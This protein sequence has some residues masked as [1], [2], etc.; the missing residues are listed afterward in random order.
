MTKDTESL[1][2]YSVPSL[3]CSLL[4]RFALRPTR[5]PEPHVSVCGTEALPAVDDD[6]VR[7]QIDEQTG[8]CQVSRRDASE[9]PKEAG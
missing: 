9:G 3:P 7:D 4:S 5:V 2:Y 6:R 8:H 1:K